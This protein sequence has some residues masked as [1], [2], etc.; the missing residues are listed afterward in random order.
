MIKH[1]NFWNFLSPNTDIGRISYN[2]GYR[3][4]LFRQSYDFRIISHQEQKL[5]DLDTQAEDGGNRLYIDK[6]VPRH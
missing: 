3:I 2:I 6:V 4:F 1:T 5:D